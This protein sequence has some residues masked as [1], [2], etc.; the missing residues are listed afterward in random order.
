MKIKLIRIHE[1][2]K[3]WGTSETHYANK[4]HIYRFILGRD[5][6]NFKKND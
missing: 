3:C 4:H 5:L 2:A 6:S 1:E